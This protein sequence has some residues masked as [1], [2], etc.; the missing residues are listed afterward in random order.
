MIQT[1]R[2]G[3]LGF[4]LA[5]PVIVKASSIMAVKPVLDDGIAL[6]SMAHPVGDLSEAALEEA[7]IRIKKMK[8]EAGRRISLVPDRIIIS[9]MEFKNGMWRRL[10][11]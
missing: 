11:T 4:L 8:D 5:A 1:S 2:R 9:D 6:T 10:V 7:I 3:F